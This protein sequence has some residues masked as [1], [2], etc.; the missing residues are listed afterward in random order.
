LLSTLAVAWQVAQ[1]AAMIRLDPKG[2]FI[3][4]S[5]TDVGKTYIACA[6]VRQLNHR[7]IKTETRKPAE[8]G[9]DLSNDGDLIAH[10]AAALQQANANHETIERICPNR[11]RA[12]LAPHRAARLEAQ[13]VT[14]QALIDACERD[15]PAH[16]LI[17]E[18][19]GGFYSPLAEDGLNA[20]LANALQLPIIIVVDDRIGAVNQALMTLQAVNSSKLHVAAV[21]LNQVTPLDDVGM[22]NASDI[23]SYCNSPVFRC[24]YNCELAQIFEDSLA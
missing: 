11:Y 9:C 14:L 6:I 5:D 23:K 10:D 1:N 2:Y 8:S 7:G 20:D 18:G 16:C 4:G 12:A 22:D 15:D 24:G 13:T 3:T 21:I 19:A 17:V